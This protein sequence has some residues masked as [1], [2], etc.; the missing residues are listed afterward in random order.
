MQPIP[1]RLKTQ[2]IRQLHTCFRS[3]YL[4]CNA[5]KVGLPVVGHRHNCW[6]KIK[7]RFA[8]HY[9]CLQVQL[10]HWLSRVTRFRTSN[11]KDSGN[12]VGRGTVVCRTEREK[13]Y[14]LEMKTSPTSISFPSLEFKY[15][16]QNRGNSNSKIRNPRNFC[17]PR[18]FSRKV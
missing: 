16:T 13:R 2:A 6:Q 8:I 1:V 14:K 7:F 12:H 17:F 18:T 3:L 10:M 4:Q 15:G 11:L 5:N 9:L